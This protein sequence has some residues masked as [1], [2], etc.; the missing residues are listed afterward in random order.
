MDITHTP[1]NIG[2][3]DAFVGGLSTDELVLRVP[4]DGGAPADGQILMTRFD[5]LQ[6][7]TVSVNLLGE[8]YIDTYLLSTSED[9]C[10]VAS[11]QLDGDTVVWDDCGYGAEHG[12][13]S[14]SPDEAAYGAGCVRDYHVEGIVDCVDDSLLASC[15]DG[16]LDRGQNELDYVYNQP[17]LT[18][19]FDDVGLERFTMEGLEYGTE[20]P[21]YTN[22]RTW[23]AF[24]GTLKSMSLEPTPDCL[25]AE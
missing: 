25:C 15:E 12:S 11:G 21:T 2:N 16:W 14:W 4:D 22:N 13:P 9:E 24:E 18:L 8:I 20:L 6:D 5:L 7:F 10:G 19:D 1:L 17:M 23:L 3:A